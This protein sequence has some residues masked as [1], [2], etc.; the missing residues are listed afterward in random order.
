M[1][2]DTPSGKPPTDWNTA[3]MRG[4]IAARYRSERMFKFMGLG[5]LS[6]AAFFLAFLLFTIIR[7]GAS[8]FRHSEVRLEIN[9]D[10]VA[11][12]I[13]RPVVWDRHFALAP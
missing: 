10:P 12:A 4:R 1:R 9:F 13:E 11:L 8:G 2:A 5:A 7:D 3:E 6:L